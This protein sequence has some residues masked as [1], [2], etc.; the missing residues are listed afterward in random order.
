MNDPINKSQLLDM[1]HTVRTQWEA[2]LAEIP[3]AWM[4]EPGVAGA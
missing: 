2:L 1:I 4:T 3:A